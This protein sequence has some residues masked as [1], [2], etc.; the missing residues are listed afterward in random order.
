[1][2]ILD[3]GE[4]AAGLI[5]EKAKFPMIRGPDGSVQRAAFSRY[6]VQVSDIAHEVLLDDKHMRRDKKTFTKQNIRAFLK[7]SL[8]REAWI[9][10]P[11]LVKEHLAIQYR[12]PMEIPAHLLQDAKLLANKQAMLSSMKQPKGRGARKSEDLARQSQELNR[13]QIAQQ[14]PHATPLQLHQLQ[15]QAYTQPVPVQRPPPQAPI[16]Y[17]IEDLDLPPKANAR[18][19]SLSFFTS[20]QAEFITSNRRTTFDDIE[21]ASMGNLLEVWNTL[22]VQCEVYQLDSFTFDDFVDAMRYDE[23]DPPCELLEE[24]FCAVL[25]QLVDVKGMLLNKSLNIATEAV[26]SAS[27]IHDDSATSTPAPD[28]PARSTRSRLSHV[29]PLN[30]HPRSPTGI[31][32][33]SNRAAEMLGDRGWKTRLASREFEDGGWQVVL[34]GLLHHVSALPHLRAQCMKILAEL[35]P[36]DSEA[37]QETALTT[38]ASL[39]INLRISALQIITMLSISTPGVKEFLETCSDDMTDVRKRKIEHQR[40]RK[41]AMEELAVKDRERKILWP[42]NMPDSPKQASAELASANGD[43]DDTLE[44]NGTSSPEPDDDAPPSG[45]SLRRGSDRKRKRNEEATRK[46]KEKAEKAEALKAQNKQSKEFKK[47]LHDIEKLKDTIASHEGFITECDA[48]LREA[49]V[50]RTKVLGK[51]RYCNRYYWFERNGQPFGG[52]P[53]SSTANYGYA[54]GRI[55]VQGPDQMESEGFIDRTSDEQKAYRLRFGVSVHERRK[56]EEGAT[57][58]KN[59]HEWGYYDDPAVIDK[60]I[61]WLDERGEREKKLRKELVDWGKYIA[62]YMQAL[63]DFRANEEAR[64]NGELEEA[65][66]ISTR[67]Q[68]HEETAEAERCL[69]WKNSELRA[70]TGY[71]HSRPK[72]TAKAKARQK[73]VAT[74]VTKP[75]TRQGERYDFK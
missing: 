47:I 23:V 22:N 37:T 13:I 66:R 71:I 24:I 49:N 18:R 40:M 14:N 31:A 55:W 67:R 30:D 73:G 74:K 7:N 61:S 9:G 53:S 29:D 69:K 12:L 21:M 15:M 45:R 63:K 70:E 68:A 25:K 43:G 54:N 48:D 72:T 6:F 50:Q 64:K 65:P 42:A 35:A 51:D 19:P 11:W 36:M 16:K 28:V 60:L 3:D 26:D 44:T 75:A 52:L 39:D 34:V 5:R 33:K 56:H 27:D 32:E 8:Q 57:A 59:A 41:A 62:Q 20:E 46:E 4:Q 38:F 58:L 10:A 17:P 1:M 2:V